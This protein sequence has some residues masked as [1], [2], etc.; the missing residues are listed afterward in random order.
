VEEN[1]SVYRVLVWNP[2]QL[3]HFKDLGPEGKIILQQMLRK[4]DGKL[5]TGFIQVMVRTSGGPF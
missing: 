1:R 2:E 5:C 4:Q 3:N